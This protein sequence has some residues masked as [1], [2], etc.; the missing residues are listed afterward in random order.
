M[1]R[2]S[3]LSSCPGSPSLLFSRAR[4]QIS[5][6]NKLPL[7]RFSLLIIHSSRTVYLGL[8]FF[9]AICNE[10]YPIMSPL[11]IVSHFVYLSSQSPLRSFRKRRWVRQHWSS[12]LRTAQSLVVCSSSCF[13]MFIWI[14]ARPFTSPPGLLLE[15]TRCLF[16]S[17]DH[18]ALAL[19]SSRQGFLIMS[20][21]SSL[22]ISSW[23]SD[24]PAFYQ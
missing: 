5:H 12:S 21:P 2:L 1:T 8:F 9:C 20:S 11:P 17:S 3:T 14:L 7:A 15:M 4:F 19:Q 22:T 6:S 13:M 18:S 10:L 23:L 24:P 16:R